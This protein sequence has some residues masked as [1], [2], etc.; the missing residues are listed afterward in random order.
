[1]S[2]PGSKASLVNMWDNGL[3]AEAGVESIYK[4]ELIFSVSPKGTKC[5]AICVFRNNS[6]DLAQN[7]LLVDQ[8]K[9][10][11]L[12]KELSKQTEMMAQD[13]IKFRADRGQWIDWAITEMLRLYDRFGGAKVIVKA[14]RLKI[15]E[16]RTSSQVAQLRSQPELL[17]TSLRTIDQL[18]G[19]DYKWDPWSKTVRRGEIN[20][21]KGKR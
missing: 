13:P 7:P 4:I 5:G 1:M 20:A 15:R 9:L 18:L 16:A 21:S 6:I 19:Q 10:E 3:A 12:E 17:F 11:Q 8:K 14:P 2:A